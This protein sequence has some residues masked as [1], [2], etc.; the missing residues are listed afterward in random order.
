M[1]QVMGITTHPSFKHIQCFV[2]R[3]TREFLVMDNIPLLANFATKQR[4]SIN[5]SVTCFSVYTEFEIALLHSL[6]E[7]YANASAIALV[8]GN[9]NSYVQMVRRRVEQMT[10]GCV[11]DVWLRRQAGWG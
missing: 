7:K 2:N 6:G 3:T 9:M 11:C 5:N 10:N 4:A 8:E 1:P